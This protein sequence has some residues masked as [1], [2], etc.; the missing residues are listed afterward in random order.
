MKPEDVIQYRHYD[1]MLHRSDSPAVIYPDGSEHWY[2]LG[3][4]H[5]EDDGPAVTY[6]EY[7]EKDRKKAKVEVW[8]KSGRCH[9]NN[10]P[11]V[12]RSDN[13]YPTVNGVPCH[14]ALNGKWLSKEEW[15][16]N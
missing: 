9:R 14:Y 1:G 3:D 12:I 5:R 6:Y 2:F 15:E 4:L 16:K 11:A 7:D 8:Y 13:N 10:G